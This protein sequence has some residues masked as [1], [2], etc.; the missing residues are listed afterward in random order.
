MSEAV[1]EA[2]AVEESL[3]AFI[4]TLRDSEI[5]Q[6]FVDASEQ[7]EADD[8]AQSL[9]KAYQQKQQQLQGNEFDSSVMS[10]LQKLQTEL[11][12]NETIQ[13]HRAAQEELV[14]L[15]EQTNDVISKQIRREFAQSLGGGCC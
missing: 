7:L 13:Q 6:Q 4:Q 5:Y 2:S 1:S 10:D 14:A 12:N 3:Q 8:E 11:S 9:L 15:L